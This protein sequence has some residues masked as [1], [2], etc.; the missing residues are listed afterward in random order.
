MFY[1]DR[2]A[3]EDRQLLRR[4]R[5]FPGPDMH[6]IVGDVLTVEQHAPGIGRRETD[7]H[8]NVVVFPAP[9]APSRPAISPELTS[10][11]TRE[12]SGRYTTS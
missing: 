8:I 5:A 11:L 12:Q 7:R 10:R 9:F 3:A 6:R 1:F 2:K 4:Y